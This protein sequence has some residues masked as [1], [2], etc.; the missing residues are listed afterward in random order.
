MAWEDYDS[1]IEAQLT[2]VEEMK[3]EISRYKDCGY[4]G[5][6]IEFILTVEYS[7]M[8]GKYFGPPEDCYP[9]ETEFDVE[10]VIM[11]LGSEKFDVTKSMWKVFA[12][13]GDTMDCAAEAYNEYQRER[14]VEKYYE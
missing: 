5:D 9:D 14:D 6:D 13:D 1:L 4:L 12:E 8:P 3:L 10:Q 7:Y 11:V 2:G